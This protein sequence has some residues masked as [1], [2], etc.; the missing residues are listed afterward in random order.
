MSMILAVAAG[1]AVGAVGRYFTVLCVSQWLG[2][3]LP[4]GTIIV[5]IVGSFALGVLIETAGVTWPLSNEL[6]AFFVVG[7]LGA[8]TT[9]SSFSSDTMTLIEHGEFL[10]AG[11]YIIASVV[12]SIGA[13]FC[14]MIFCRQLLT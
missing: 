12:L 13:L 4:Y 3:G 2:Q 7:V 8:Y 6:R 11:S 1:G 10:Q 5:N 9:F 14:G